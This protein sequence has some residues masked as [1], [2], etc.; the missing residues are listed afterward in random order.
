M[1]SFHCYEDLPTCGEGGIRTHGGKNH[2]RRY[3]IYQHPLWDN[4]IKFKFSIS[5]FKIQL[6]VLWHNYSSDK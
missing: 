2:P 1:C 4:K 6:Y 3:S 5:R